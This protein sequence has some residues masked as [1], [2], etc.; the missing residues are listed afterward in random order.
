MVNRE[1]GN[2]LLPFGY[3][4]VKVKVDMVAAYEKNDGNNY[5][6]FYCHTEKYN[7]YKLVYGFGF[8]PAG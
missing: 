4:Q 6:E 3:S 7:E 8:N 5:Y 2:L 1:M